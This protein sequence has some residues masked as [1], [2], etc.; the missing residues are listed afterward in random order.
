MGVGAHTRNKQLPAEPISH[1]AVGTEAGPRALERY[2]NSRSGKAFARKRF[3]NEAV[4]P[5]TPGP[6]Q[7][8]VKRL[9]GT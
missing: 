7:V 4:K 1:V 3:W 8:L 2:F 5:E 6:E 9:Q